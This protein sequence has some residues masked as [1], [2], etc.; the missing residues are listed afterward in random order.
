MGVLAG[1]C[2]QNRPAERGLAAL[3]LFAA[4]RPHALRCCGDKVWDAEQS[5]CHQ[6][7][8][9]PSRAA[10]LGRAGQGRLLLCARLP[11]IAAGVLQRQW[12]LNPLTSGAPG[13]PGLPAFLPPAPPPPAPVLLT[14]VLWQLISEA[15]LLVVLAL[16]AVPASK[17]DSPWGLIHPRHRALAIPY[18]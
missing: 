4:V 8:A 7:V 11:R 9:R 2:A 12:L 15:P 3:V 5:E 13:R 18:H 17:A 14:P 16:T 6:E 10:A 1:H